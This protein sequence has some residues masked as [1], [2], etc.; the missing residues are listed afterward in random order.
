[1]A[2]TS[3]MAAALLNRMEPERRYDIPEL[4]ALAPDLSS[5]AIRE[6]MREL[7][8]DRQVERAEPSGW[9]RHRSSSGQQ[10]AGHDGDPPE[11]VKPEDLFDHAE[12]PAFFK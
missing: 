2:V 10:R 1:M 4:R 5:E 12:F 9:R 3:D 6:L 8:I 7:W 11:V